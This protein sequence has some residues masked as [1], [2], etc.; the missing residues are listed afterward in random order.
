VLTKIYFKEPQ[1]TV[2]ALESK[3]AYNCIEEEK[4]NG[5][6]R[7]N[8]LPKFLNPATIPPNREIKN[9]MMNHNQFQEFTYQLLSFLIT[10]TLN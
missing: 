1:A 5:L 10:S 8:K 6:L 2:K 7:Y 3:G 4:T 9:L